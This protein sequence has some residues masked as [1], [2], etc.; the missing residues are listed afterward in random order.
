MILAYAATRLP[1]QNIRLLLLGDGP[2]KEYLQNLAKSEK[3]EDKVVF[4]DFQD[5]PFKFMKSARFTILTSKHEGLPNIITES[6]TCGIPVVAFDCKSG[7][8]EL[9]ENGKNGL[10]VE[11]QNFDE[12][13]KAMNE[14]NENEALRETCKGNAFE[15]IKRFSVEKIGAEWLEYLKIK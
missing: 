12:F 4:L 9:I 5:N 7:P 2:Q 11:D 13:V 15:S 3:L 14:M 10:L 8:G 1:A 6:L